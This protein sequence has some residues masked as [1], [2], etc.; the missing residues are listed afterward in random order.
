MENEIEVNGKK[1][2]LKTDVEAEKVE[3]NNFPKFKLVVKE[4]M[5]DEANVLGIGS[6]E[7]QGDYHAV[8]LSAEYLEKI[9]KLLKQFS[10]SKQGFDKI[11][12]V[13]ADKYPC[14]IGRVGENNMVSG[15]I[16]A[17]IVEH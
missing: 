16:L 14:I 15:F 1:Y 5:L 6:V 7:V 2:V 12:I 4:M 13:W 10:L 3:N 17:P 8:R 11:D 9:V